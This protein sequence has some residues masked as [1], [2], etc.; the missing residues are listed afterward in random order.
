MMAKSR[1]VVLFVSL[2]LTWACGS[3]PA[4]EQP[5]PLTVDSSQV[6]VHTEKSMDT[7]QALK[8]E[9]LLSS[10]AFPAAAIGG[11]S[12]GVRIS[13]QGKDS[14]SPEAH[15]YDLLVNDAPSS[16][17]M[18]AIGN[19]KREAKWFSLPPGETV[20]MHWKTMGPSLFPGAGE[21]RLQLKTPFGTG[22]TARVVIGQ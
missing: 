14:L 15:L 6:A 19:G 8:V 20:E 10:Q 21:Y 2:V 22:D 18:L 7:T 1:N 11:F 5:S 9:L 13:N 16:A 3:Q 17:F 4:Q 12:I